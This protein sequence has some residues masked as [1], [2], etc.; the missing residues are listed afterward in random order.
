VLG[1]LP[2]PSLCR[3]PYTAIH[4]CNEKWREIVKKLALVVL[5]LSSVFSPAFADDKPTSLSDA[6]AAIDANLR[7]LE[8]KAFDEQIGKEFVEKHMGPLRQ[9][10]QS[11]GSDLSSFWIL[12]KLD[13]DGAV[14][15]VLLY[16]STKLG[17]CAREAL[18]KDKLSPP[19]RAG[20]WVGVYMKISH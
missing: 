11:A 15:E 16:P 4:R 7:T 10:K 5:L 3:N 12:L 18:L 20:Y 14:K 13:K 1:R 17:N 19:P 9:C 6:R 2:M 8:G